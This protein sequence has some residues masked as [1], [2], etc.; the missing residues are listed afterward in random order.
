MAE[1]FAAGDPRL[2]FSLA[3]VGVVAVGAETDDVLAYV[4][5]VLLRELGTGEWDRLDGMPAITVGTRTFDLHG[6]AD[7]DELRTVVASAADP[8]DDTASRPSWLTAAPIVALFLVALAAL[9][10]LVFGVRAT[11]VAAAF[12]CGFVVM[13]RL[14]QPRAR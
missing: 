12:G 10:W 2:D 1:A 14:R 13:K 6:L 9:I 11:V 5:E 7:L 8:S 4:G 3:S